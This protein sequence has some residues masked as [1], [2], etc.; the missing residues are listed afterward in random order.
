MVNGCKESYSLGSLI[1]TDRRCSNRDFC[2]FYDGPALESNVVHEG[3]YICVGCN[4]ELGIDAF[5]FVDSGTINK[6]R[7][8]QMPDGWN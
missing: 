1:T 3:K 5:T 7:D 6:S 8:K 4:D 2:D